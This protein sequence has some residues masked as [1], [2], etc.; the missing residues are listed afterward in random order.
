MRW[1][2]SGAYNIKVENDTILKH[3]YNF[4]FKLNQEFN[5]YYNSTIGIS[6]YIVIKYYNEDTKTYIINCTESTSGGIL[7]RTHEIDDSNIRDLVDK[8]IKNPEDP[9]F[10]DITH[11]KYV[12][13]ISEWDVSD[14]TDMSGLFKNN[15]NFNEFLRNWD[16]S[17]IKN[18]KLMFQNT[19]LMLKKKVIQKHLILI[20]GINM[21]L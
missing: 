13:H 2:P 5:Y 9:Q 1:R 8:W 10:T 15:T 4:E 20:A 16:I 12:G 21:I 7:Y 3:G 14:V 6:P 17:N 11:I 19:K 18:T